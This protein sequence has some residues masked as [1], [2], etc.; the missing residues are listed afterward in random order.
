MMPFY[1]I[2]EDIGDT[3]SS[4]GREWVVY[5][6]T[7]EEAEECVQDSNVEERMTLRINNITAGG[8]T[9]IV[10]GPVS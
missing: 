2:Y 9:R 1:L 4:S 5:A 8:A 7:K 3:T 6:S 10:L